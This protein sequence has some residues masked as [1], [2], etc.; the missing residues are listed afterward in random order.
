MQSL[1]PELLIAIDQ[2]MLAWTWGLTSDQIFE[3]RDKLL[4]AV[5]ARRQA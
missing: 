4:A 5:A 1:R 3:E 2:R